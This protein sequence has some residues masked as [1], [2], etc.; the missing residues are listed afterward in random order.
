MTENKILN[1]SNGR[2]D[3]QKCSARISKSRRTEQASREEYFNESRSLK[4]SH[5]TPCAFW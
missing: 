2:G 1:V 3:A 4:T 5:V